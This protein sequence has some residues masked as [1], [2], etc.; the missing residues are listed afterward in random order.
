MKFRQF[1]ALAIIASVVLAACAP[2]AAPAAPAQPAAPAAPAATTA[3]AADTKPT[4]APAPASS[5]GKIQLRLWSHDNPAF[6]KVNQELVAKFMKEN[7]DIEV[8]Y[9]WFPYEQ[10]IQTLQ[11]SMASKT[12]ADVI[13]MFGT[14][15][16]GYANGGRL[17]EMPTDVMSY[18]EAQKLFFQ[19]P[20][21]GYYCNGKLYGLPQEFNLENGG[22]LV[23]PELFKKAGLPYPPDWKSFDD[24]V[25]AAKKLTEVND[26][27]EMGVAGFHYTG[28]DGLPF[29]FIAGILQQG[30]NYFASDN[31][32]FNFN[33]PEAK[34]MAQ[35]MV[36]WAQKDKIIDPV[37]FNGN[38]GS[39]QLPDAFFTG[40]VGIGFIGSWAAG[41]GLQSY[42][43]FKFDYVTLPPYFGTQNI[44]AADAGW[45]KVVSVNTKHAD[46]AWKLAK[47]FTADPA[48]AMNWNATT[49]TIPA[50]KGTVDNPDEFL[51]RAPWV[52][53]TFPLLPSGKYLGDLTDRDQLFYEIIAKH[54]LDAAQGTTSV[55]DAI[56][57]INDE[58]N[59][60][61]D[62]KK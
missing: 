13:E 60:M 36:D 8:K 17:A 23:N 22:V 18:A 40:K 21:D 51:K 5:D 48:N 52:K 20:I 43:D 4:E 47:F 7:P 30:G 57:A 1:S 29:A 38:Q 39:L 14:W 44:Y 9:E 10:L 25:A 58:A 55:D 54:L 2:A 42:P 46:A 37:I 45:G 35:K 11:T 59:A 61:V 15:T 19:A 62:A 49:G 12:E 56:K 24:V 26:K 33:T 6:V 16:C 50:L 53:A 34:N 3:P 41:T 28:G 31:K 27:G 32:H